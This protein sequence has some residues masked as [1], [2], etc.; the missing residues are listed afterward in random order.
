MR[1]IPRAALLGF[2]LWSCGGSKL[3]APPPVFPLKSAWS[4]PL[5]ATIEGELASDGRLVFASLRGGG[6]R[7]VEPATGHVVWEGQHA[8]GRLAAAEGALL[9]AAADGALLRIEPDSGVVRWRTATKVTGALTPALAGQR[10][11]AAGKG[12]AALD[13]VSGELLWQAE[14]G[15]AS[16]PPLVAGKTLLI[17]E[18]DGTLRARDVDS[19]RTLWTFATGARLAAAPAVDAN[20]RVFLGTTARGFVA[21]SLD[22]G[23]QLWRWRL[24]ADVQTPPAVLGGNVVFGTHESVLY[25]LNRRNGNLAWRQTLPS[26][27]RSGPLLLDSAILVA[28]FE[29]DLVGF[30]GRTGRRLG[31]LKVASTLATAPVLVGTR[32]FVGLRDRG[33]LSAVDLATAAPEPTPAPSAAPTP[34]ASPSA[35]PSPGA[36]PSPSPT[37]APTPKPTPAAFS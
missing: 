37:P 33:T 31:G 3:L 2:L 27:P 22:K 1:R 8:L 29:T 36:T 6:V 17:G 16:A 4:T 35:S 34:A 25:A 14:D 11:F 5:G 21:V 32:L 24:G 23:R 10:V 30:D 26:R 7:A 9:L 18:A 28:C 13:L 20:R 19:G 15:D 12:A